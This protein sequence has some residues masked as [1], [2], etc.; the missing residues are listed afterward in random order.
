MAARNVTVATLQFD[1]S[2][3]ANHPHYSCVAVSRSLISDDTD[4]GLHLSVSQVSYIRWA[5]LGL[6]WN[7]HVKMKLTTLCAEICW[8]QWFPEAA[9]AMVP[10]VQKYYST[11][12]QLAQKSEP[13]NQSTSFSLSLQA[14]DSGSCGC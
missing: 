10:Q 6:S 4:L 7:H 11:L 9:W 1:C 14:S 12:L 13:Q 8:D 5:S 2:K 3:E